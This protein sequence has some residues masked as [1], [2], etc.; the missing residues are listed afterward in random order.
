ML[1]A[2]EVKALARA[3]ESETVEF[4]LENEVQP[5]IAELLAAFANASGGVTL[6]GITDDGVVVGVSRP[7]Q[8]TARI[9]AAA[10]SCKPPLDEALTVYTVSVDGKE[11]VVATL[12]SLDDAVYS[13]AGAFR[14]RSGSSNIALSDTAL[15][16]LV[17][18][19]RGREFDSR[20]VASASLDDLD[21]TSVNQLIEARA[22][23]T[24]PT[25]P[26]TQ[27]SYPSDEA[28]TQLQ[29][30]GVLTA[31][32]GRLVPTVAGLLVAGRE[33]QTHIPGASLQIARF[34]GTQPVE[35]L[36]R[37]ELTGNIPAQIKAA[38]A[39]VDRTTSFAAKI[40][41]GEREDIRQFPPAAVREAIINALLHRDYQTTAKVN[42]SIFDDRIEVI[43]P[44][45]LLPGVEL[46]HIVGSHLLRNRTLGPLLLWLRWVE[47]WGTGIRRMKAAMQEA[48]LPKPVF[49]ATDNWFQVTLTGH[50][51]GLEPTS[52]VEQ[53]TGVRVKP[54]VKESI[55]RGLNE[56]QQTLL[57]EFS[58]AG[59][60]RISA[61]GYGAKF[62]LSPVQ[63]FRD[64][65]RLVEVGL[66]E[67]IGK[68]KYTVYVM[69][70]QNSPGN[71]QDEMM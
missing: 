50:P 71:I 22:S 25:S 5:D 15:Y 36:D 6:F 56:R 41:G 11:V 29:A 35:F 30:L 40:G 16:D 20:P 37:A 60:G 27:A 49:Q 17:L 63:S 46:E 69:R 18:R 28:N 39:F 14:R 12:P 9:R 13:Y 7:N 26:L 66:L 57:R 51:T 4:K 53:P 61:S 64:L 2:V 34:R 19:R 44:G 62:N 55:W 68:G 45:G 52:L 8:L 42:V 10:R 1:S 23:F 47:S 65:R 67:R 38:L 32:A 70:E 54:L 21:P 24:A 59:G 48:G 33:P 43:N 3:G 58:A 31:G